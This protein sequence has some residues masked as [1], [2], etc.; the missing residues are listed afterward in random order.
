[1]NEADE[2]DVALVIAIADSAMRF[3][4]LEKVRPIR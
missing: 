4:A 1:M 3:D 2:I